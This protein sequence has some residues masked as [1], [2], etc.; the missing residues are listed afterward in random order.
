ML[1]WNAF[2]TFGPLLRFDPHALPEG[3]DSAHGV[4]YGPSTG[5]CGTWRGF[6]VDR[7]IDRELDRP[8]LTG[9]SFSRPLVLGLPADS[10]GAWATRAGGERR[11]AL[12][13]FGV[14]VNPLMV[15]GGFRK[16]IH[17]LLGDSRPGPRAKLGTHGRQA[18]SGV[19][20]GAHGVSP[21]LVRKVRFLHVLLSSMVGR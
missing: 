8:Y 1:A 9:L 6:S 17:L 20:N 19:G 11:M 13:A 3:E 7:T 14:D 4:W 10:R 16:L 18:L 2:R 15:T 21:F 5:R 12:G